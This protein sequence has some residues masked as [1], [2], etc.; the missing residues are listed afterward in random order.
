METTARGVL[1]YWIAGW[2]NQTLEVY[3]R[4]NQQLKSAATPYRNDELTSPLLPGFQ[5]QV[6][7]L[8]A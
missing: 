7:E 6:G 8:F 1:E 2:R 4:E 5:V 3:Q